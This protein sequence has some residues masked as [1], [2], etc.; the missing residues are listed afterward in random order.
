MK[1]LLYVVLLCVL[2][3]CSNEEVEV[4]EVQANTFEWQLFRYSGGSTGSVY[5]PGDITWQFNEDS[6]VLRKIDST[7]GPD[8]VIIDEYSYEFSMDQLSIWTSSTDLINYDYGVVKNFA[9]LSCCFVPDLLDS[10]VNYE[11]WID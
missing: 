2:I 4:N 6:S 10:G 9:V 8:N 1:R 3:S 5:Q 11:F 7:E